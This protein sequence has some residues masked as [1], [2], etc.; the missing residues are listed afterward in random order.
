MI[1]KEKQ[2]YPYCWM[3]SLGVI[4]RNCHGNPEA[5]WDEEKGWFRAPCG[6]QLGSTKFEDRYD[7]Y[8]SKLKAN[9]SNLLLASARS[10]AESTK[11][12]CQAEGNKEQI[13]LS[14]NYSYLNQK[15]P[16]RK[17]LLDFGG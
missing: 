5:V 10:T 11:N 14:V 16:E 15:N 3:S 7:F 12:G 9:R 1:C 2:R 8:G 17:L 13:S 4:H 6:R